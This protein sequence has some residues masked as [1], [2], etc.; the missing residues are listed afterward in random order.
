MHVAEIHR[1]IAF[2]ADSLFGL[3]G[4]VRGDNGMQVDVAA[5]EHDRRQKDRPKRK[6]IDLFPNG[7]AVFIVLTRDFF[8][9]KIA[10]LKEGGKHEKVQKKGHEK[11]LE[12]ERADAD[13]GGAPPKDQLVFAFACIHAA[14]SCTAAQK[15]KG[16]P[17]NQRGQKQEYDVKNGHT[18]HFLL[19]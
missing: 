4:I 19:F 15:E 6:R 17:G 18:A 10:Q 3:H 1:A 14:C 8:E 2:L 13:R 5:D 16:K 9:D 7:K 12:N 11:A